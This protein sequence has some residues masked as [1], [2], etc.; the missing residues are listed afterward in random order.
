MKVL[1]PLRR[2]KRK[3]E[4]EVWYLRWYH[5]SLASHRMGG[6]GSKTAE[7]QFGKAFEIWIK[8]LVGA[9]VGPEKEDFP[10]IKGLVG[11]FFPSRI[12]RSVLY[13]FFVTTV[14]KSRQY[15]VTKSLFYLLPNVEK[16]SKTPK[17]G[18]FICYLLQKGVHWARV[19]QWEERWKSSAG[20]QSCLHLYRESMKSQHRML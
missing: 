6:G 11:Y 3:R 1:Q 16:Q 17:P 2:Q 7:I 12:T 10:I 18:D 13:P 4:M 5:R 19:A 20:F 15:Q 14:Y 9:C 8:W